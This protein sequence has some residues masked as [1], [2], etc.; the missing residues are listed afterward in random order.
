MSEQD[1]RFKECDRKGTSLQGTSVLGPCLLKSALWKEQ[2]ITEQMRLERDLCR[3]SSWKLKQGQLEQAAQKH[4]Q[5]WRLHSHS[6]HP[7]AAFHH[8]H[9]IILIF[10]IFQ[11]VPRSSWPFTG[12]HW[13]EYVS[14]FFTNFH[15]VFRNICK[16]PPRFCSSRET[17]PPLLASSYMQ[18]IP[19]L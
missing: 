5:G 13:Q 15:N 17:V 10:I 3:L 14:I 2:S 18:Y 16:I 12:H 7:V 6:A 1:T 11:C 8:P 19:M 4:L 9:C